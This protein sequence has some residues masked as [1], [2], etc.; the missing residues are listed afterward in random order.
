M[1]TGIYI[2]DGEIEETDIEGMFT[3]PAFVDLEADGAGSIVTQSL[4][5]CRTIDLPAD[6]A[7]GDAIA[8]DAIDFIVRAILHDGTGMTVLRL[9]RA[10]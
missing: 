9:S 8:V 7:E 5:T 2:L 6:A 4:F 10:D 1:T 3:G